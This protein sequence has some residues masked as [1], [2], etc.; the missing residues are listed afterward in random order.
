MVLEFPNLVDKMDYDVN[1][2]NILGTIKEKNELRGV[3]HM[4][5]E[6]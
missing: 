5:D 1:D 4:G 3:E 2:E 6:L